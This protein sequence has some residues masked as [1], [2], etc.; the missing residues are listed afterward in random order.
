MLTKTIFACVLFLVPVIAT[1]QSDVELIAEATSPLPDQLRDGATV[2]VT[3]EAG[4]RRV[5]RQGTNALVCHPDGPTPIGFYV[6]CSD[7]RLSRSA[8]T[9]YGKLRAQGLSEDEILARVS[10]GVAAGTLTPI[11]SGA[12]FYALSGPDKEH[13]DLLVVMRLPDA[14]AESTGLSTE[15]SDDSAWLMF[16][17]TH[18]AHVMFGSP[19]YWWSPNK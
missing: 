1:A 12:M 11:P 8:M 3:D 16:S 14:T 15:P 18:Q 13:A 5:L 2:I 4:N 6:S 7:E 19:P 9:E 17:G 10:A